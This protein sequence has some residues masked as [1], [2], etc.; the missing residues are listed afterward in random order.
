MPTNAI[1]QTLDLT[2]RE[3]IPTGDVA[4]RSFACFDRGMR[5]EEVVT[6]LTLPADTA[7]YLWRTWARL[8]GFVPLSGEVARALREALYSNR[9]MMNCS[10][11]VA[12]AQRFAE[13]PTRVCARCKAACP[14]YCT[15]CPTREAIRAARKSG[16]H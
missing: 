13:R 9:P 7:E 12:A 16:R 11:V 8:R 2:M 4:A 5:P 14:E 3:A 1:T 10:D 15:A 6:H